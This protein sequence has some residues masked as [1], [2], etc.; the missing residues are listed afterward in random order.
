MV[1]AL[2]I[3]ARPQATEY[4]KCTE[5]ERTTPVKQNVFCKDFWSLQEQKL[6]PK[7]LN[8]QNTC[9]S[10]SKHS[11]STKKKSIGFSLMFVIRNLLCLQCFSAG[12]FVNGCFLLM[13]CNIYNRLVNVYIAKTCHQIFMSIFQFGKDITVCFV[14][15]YSSTFISGRRTIVVENAY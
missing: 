8:Y 12:Y 9:G 5:K 3:I 10:Y 4:L 15:P 13:R 2:K 7:N 6:L 11:F 14:L 1:Q